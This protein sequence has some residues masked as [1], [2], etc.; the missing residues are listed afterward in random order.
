VWL[1]ALHAGPTSP[2]AGC[3][4]QTWDP[5][6]DALAL[7]WPKLTGRL[8]AVDETWTG[9]RVEGKCNKSAC[10]DPSTGRGG[11]DNPKRTCVTQNFV[12]TLAG[13]YAI[14]DERW[15]LVT[16]TWTDGHGPADAGNSVGNWSERVALVSLEH[17]RPA[18]ARAVIHY[19]FPQ[20]LADGWGAVE[21]T[22]EMQ[23][24]DEC[25]G[26]LA[27][28]GWS[29][30]AADVQE[31]LDAADALARSDELRHSRRSRDTLEQPPQE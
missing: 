13:V 31:A 2:T 29:R 3:L 5:I 25:P 27:A 28:M 1:S 15:A 10:A 17:G 7:G 23:S 30:G 6:E 19:N 24:I 18:W 21:R 9:L 12:E 22:W 26:S 16:T 20:Q 8:T 11:A 14:G 4:G